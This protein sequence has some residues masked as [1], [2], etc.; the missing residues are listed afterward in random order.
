M[1][2]RPDRLQETIQAF[3]EPVALEHQ[4]GD[5]GTELG[6]LLPDQQAVPPD[7]P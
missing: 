1:R 7:A 2:M 4:V 6:E 5:G 3:Q